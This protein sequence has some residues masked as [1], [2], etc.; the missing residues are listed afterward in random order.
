MTDERYNEIVTKLAASNDASN[1]DFQLKFDTNPQWL[2]DALR[3]LMAEVIHYRS[4]YAPDAVLA[5]VRQF[6]GPAGPD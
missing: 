2:I 1:G 3:D 6:R 5:R 4:L